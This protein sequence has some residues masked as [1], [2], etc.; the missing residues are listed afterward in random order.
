MRPVEGWY[1]FCKYHIEKKKEKNIV[2]V[3]LYFLSKL[4]SFKYYKAHYDAMA[5]NI[6]LKHSD[7][8]KG[9]F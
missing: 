7:K 1:N 4:I 6:L 5:R 8:I 2:R 3:L 9:S